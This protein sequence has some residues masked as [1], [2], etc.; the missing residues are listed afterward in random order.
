MEEMYT[1]WH[2]RR[3]T[4]WGAARAAL[5]RAVMTRS[6]RMVAAVTYMDAGDQSC[7]GGLFGVL[8]LQIE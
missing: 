3:S 6:E 1:P 2:E 7:A 8:V 5:A 4:S